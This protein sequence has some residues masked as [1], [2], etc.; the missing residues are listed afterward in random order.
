MRH[1]KYKR[2]AAE[3]VLQ[4]GIHLSRS[5]EFNELLPLNIRQLEMK[6]LKYL[7]TQP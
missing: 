1:T 7:T 6:P 3:L 2:M 4:H 5:K